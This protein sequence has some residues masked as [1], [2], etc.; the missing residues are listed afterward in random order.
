[1]LR[2]INL[3]DS[4]NGNVNT[5]THLIDRICPQIPCL[6][7]A[8]PV[9]LASSCATPTLWQHT[10]AFEWRPDLVCKVMLPTDTNQPFAPIVVFSQ[11]ADVHPPY[12]FTRK[13]GWQVGRPLDDVADRQQQTQ[14]R[15][16]A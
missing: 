7:T 9:P 13:L 15:N 11:T 8:L 3:S 6:A 5:E 16:S 12:V 10:S 1:L 2:D 14:M 4:T